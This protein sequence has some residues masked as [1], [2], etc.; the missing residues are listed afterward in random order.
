MG[1]EVSWFGPVCDEDY[2]FLGVPDPALLSSWEHCRGIVLGAE[3]AGYDNLL[4][5]SGYP[6]GLDSLAFAAGIAPLLRRMQLLVAVRMGRA[7]EG[8]GAVRATSTEGT[9]RWGKRPQDSRS[10]RWSHWWVSGPSKRK[11]RMGR[12]G[13]VRAGLA[14]SGIRQGRTWSSA[15]P[16]TCQDGRTISGRW[17]KA[18][19][20]ADFAIDFYLTHR[21]IASHQK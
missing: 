16:S 17:E 8:A 18:E 11:G 20:G 7:G 5:P 10:G 12:H 15:S 13:L 3:E 9:R 14:A 2:E 4:L 21:K 1:C 19:D 6:A